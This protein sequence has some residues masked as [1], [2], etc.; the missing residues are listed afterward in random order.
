MGTPGGA[1]V[2]NGTAFDCVSNEITLLHSRFI[3]GTF[4]VCNNGAIMARSLFVEGNNYTSQLTVT[5]TSDI[6][7]KDIVCAND[8]SDSNIISQ[9]STVIP[10]YQ[11]GIFTWLL[12][13][14]NNS[15]NVAII[16]NSDNRPSSTS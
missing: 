14:N 12:H 9:F 7:G 11:T 6:A 5:I 10:T 13:N 3:N 2:W 8:T 16:D 15:S 4:G 1:S